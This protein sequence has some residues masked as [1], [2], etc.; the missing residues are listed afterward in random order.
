MAIMATHFSRLFGFFHSTQGGRVITRQKM[1]YCAVCLIVFGMLFIICPA[2]HAVAQEVDQTYRGRRIDLTDFAGHR[3]SCGPYDFTTDAFPLQISNVRF[4]GPADSLANIAVEIDGDGIDNDGDGFSDCSDPEGYLAVDSNIGTPDRVS[5]M[6][7]S[8]EDKVD[9]GFRHW[10]AA[11]GD[12]IGDDRDLDD[13][14]GAHRA[15]NTGGRIL[16]VSIFGGTTE[17]DFNVSQPGYYILSL[18]G[19]W[20]DTRA[21]YLDGNQW[22]PLPQP[23]GHFAQYYLVRLS[24]PAARFKLENGY[25]FHAQIFKVG[26]DPFSGSA[27]DPLHPRLYFKPGDIQHLKDRI[28][29]VAVLGNPTDSYRHFLLNG[30][31]SASF[32]L[33]ADFSSWQDLADPRTFSNGL[34]YLALA[35]VLTDNTDFAGKLIEMMLLAASWDSGWGRDRSVLK[36]GE[37]LA[38]MAIAYDL[39]Y[40]YLTP[41]QRDIIRRAL[42]RECRYL[43]VKSLNAE[44]Y[45][46]GEYWWASEKSNNW[47]AVVHGG[48]GVAGLALLNESKYAQDYVDQAV[49]ISKRFMDTNFDADGAYQESFMYYEYALEYLMIFVEALKNVSGIDLY[50]YNNEVIQKSTTWHLYGVEPSKASMTP[51]DNDTE[52]GFVTSPYLLAVASAYDDP[53]I[54]WH[55]NNIAGLHR[56]RAVLSSLNMGGTTHLVPLVLLWYDDTVAQTPPGGKLPLGAVWPDFGRAVSLTGFEA[57]DGIHFALQSGVGGFHGNHQ[58]QGSFFLSAYGE[59]L[60]GEGGVYNFEDS[61][62]HNIIMIDGTGQGTPDLEQPQRAGIA[63]FLHSDLVD[64]IEADT[65]HAYAYKRGNPVQKASRQVLFVRPTD[66][67]AAYFVILDQVEKGDGRPHNYEF[68]LHSTKGNPIKASAGNRF[69]IDGVQA[70]LEVFFAQ[71]AA[72]SSSIDT[73]HDVPVLKA[74]AASAQFEGLFF[75]LLFPTSAQHTLPAIRATE[76]SQASVMHVG[77]DI[78]LFNKTGSSITYQNLKTDGQIAI[79]RENQNLAFAA[80]FQAT[81]LTYNQIDYVRTDI[82]TNMVFGVSEDSYH[83]T[84]GNESIEKSNSAATVTLGGLVPRGTYPLTDN[85]I[86]P[87]CFIASET[88]FFSLETVLNQKHVYKIDSIAQ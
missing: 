11:A 26:T 66:T 27:P 54:M 46:D 43:W 69:R 44:H 77:D 57:G 3:S 68:L 34:S 88:G 84:I 19:W 22:Q 78:I 67:T 63:G 8:L 75:T 70:G 15:A 65:T 13:S 20:R 72:I 10:S 64:Y 71:P 87:G 80:V 24:Q 2:T 47:A 53:L 37:M 59:R 14:M 12:P 39:V 61:K 36:N 51:F 49:K 41:Y 35:Y 9:F 52:N 1:T 85:G 73:E 21:Y 83:L 30:W 74:A 86:D 31:G 45:G 58:D 50:R 25:H 42:D 29:D 48:L 62:Y 40:H 60:V 56:N 82:I 79:I 7:G 4:N 32:Y 33:A 18:F 17:W 38:G 81:E 16:E 23:S 5:D 76:T 6:I 28:E 55:W